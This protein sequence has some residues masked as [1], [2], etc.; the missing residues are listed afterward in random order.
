MVLSFILAKSTHL[1]YFRNLVHCVFLTLCCGRALAIETLEFS[2]KS[3]V[4][5]S[6][7]RIVFKFRECLQ[8]IEY[9]GPGS[10]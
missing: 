1:H 7:K 2:V 8:K 10:S 9:R 3:G 6:D 4:L 5:V